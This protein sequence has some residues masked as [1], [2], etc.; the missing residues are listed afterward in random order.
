MEWLDLFED[1]MEK[2]SISHT[3][4]GTYYVSHLVI[5]GSQVSTW[6]MLSEDKHICFEEYV[7]EY[8]SCQGI[9]IMKNLAKK[10]FLDRTGTP[11][12]YRC[13]FCCSGEEKKYFEYTTERGTLLTI[14]IKGDDSCWGL[15]ETSTEGEIV[16]K[17]CHPIKFCPICGAK[18]S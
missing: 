6:G 16:E 3:R 17:T 9:E 8:D 5:Y 11:E 18:L 15:T 4:L 13:S 10:D 2:I 1:P 12:N 7:D 14:S